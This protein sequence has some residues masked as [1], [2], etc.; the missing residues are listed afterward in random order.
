ML[1]KPEKFMKHL[2]FRTRNQLST[3]FDAWLTHHFN[4]KILWKK[5][6]KAKFTLSRLHLNRVLSFWK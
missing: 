4:Q 5:M 1:N 3:F 6:I 2:D